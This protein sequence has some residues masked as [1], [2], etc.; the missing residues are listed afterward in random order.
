MLTN[1]KKHHKQKWI[2]L[3]K[4]IKK[5]IQT[6]VDE[7]KGREKKS[8]TALEGRSG[9]NKKKEKLVSSCNKKQTWEGIK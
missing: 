8:E 3:K 6:K 1:L 7:I 5:A 2:K 9:K 4:E